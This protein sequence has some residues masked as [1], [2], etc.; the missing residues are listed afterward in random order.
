MSDDDTTGKGQVLVDLYRDL[1]HPSAVEVGKS[2]GGAVRTILRPANFV[3]WSVDQV[4]DFAAHA[5][6][7]TLKRRNVPA[8]R[9][10]EPAIEVAGPV[11]NALRLPQQDETLRNMFV[12][13]LAT[14]MDSESAPLAHP[15]FAQI[16][17]QLTPDEARIVLLF[18]QR[19]RHP[20]VLVE[21]HLGRQEGRLIVFTNLTL[22]PFTAECRH[23][24]LGPA[25]IDNI[26]R[27]GL[28][29]IPAI[30]HLS[31]QDSYDA[32]LAHVSVADAITYVANS[33]GDRNETSLLV[34]PRVCLQTYGYTPVVEKKFLEVTEFG[35]Q[36]VRACC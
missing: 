7:E 26:C 35:K 30:G 21:A 36:F 19:H 3:V 31:A 29:E 15:A 22:M 18:S 25:Y 16:I 27:L 1:V 2:L 32:L 10:I 28:A 13:L 4:F 9:V 12:N 11:L 33:D 20:L 34:S 5:V 17:Q 23:P 14:A 24:G 6:Q 8:A